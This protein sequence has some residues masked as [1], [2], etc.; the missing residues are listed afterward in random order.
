MWPSDRISDIYIAEDERAATT[1][2]SEAG[3]FV[4]AF[5]LEP[6]TYVQKHGNLVLVFGRPPPRE[7]EAQQVADCA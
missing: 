6:A 1:A 4:R 5:G 2:Q 7:Q 3:N